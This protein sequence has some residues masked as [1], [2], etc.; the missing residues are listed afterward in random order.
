MISSRLFFFTLAGVILAV[1]PVLGGE[2]VPAAADTSVFPLADLVV[3]GGI[4]TSPEPGET[5][6]L[7]DGIALRDPG[8]LADLG[9][10][11]PSVSVAV[12]SRGD[13]HLMIRGAPE[14]HVQ[15]FLDGIPLN[16]PWDERVDLETIPITGTGRLAERRGLPTLLDG[17]GALAGS[18]RIL[19][20]DRLPGGNQRTDLNASAGTQ[21]LGRVNLT[22][23]RHGGTWNL[24]TAG[25]WQGRD[26]FPLP[27]S[28][29]P[30]FNSDL[31]QYSLLVRASRPVAGTGKFSFLATG[32][33]VE[34][35]VPPELHL[36]DEARFWRYPVRER[37]LAGA[38]LSLPLASDAWD[39]TA[40]LAADFFHQEIDPR[41]PDGWGL[42]TSDGQD[43]EKDF[44]R[45]AHLTAGLTRWLGSSGQ[46]TLQTNLRYTNHRESIVTGGGVQGFGQT[47]GGMVLEGEFPPARDW[48]LRL[49]AGMDFAMTPEA[50][51]KPKTDG[52]TAEAWNLRLTR[53]LGSRTEVYAST[54][55]RSRFPSLRELYSGALGKF[56]PNPD[57]QPERQDLLEIGFSAGKGRWKLA[58]AAFLQYLRQGIEK[59][60]L[61]GPGHRFMRVNRTEIRV[62]GL[63]IEGGWQTGPDLR[64]FAQHTVLA[65]RVETPTGF[66]QPAE[67]RP[68]YLSRLGLDWRRNTGPGLLVE[69][70]I[71]GARWSADATDLVNGLTRLPAAVSWNLRL[72]WRWAAGND[73]AG[74]HRTL[75]AHLRVDNLFDQTSCYQAG[76]PG[77]GRIVSAGLGLGF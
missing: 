13:S 8:S 71:T 31:S 51:D 14:R 57:L 3:S 26:S 43:Y 27:G 33:T 6:I 15:I 19:P 74:P 24:L 39:L 41:G 42:P 50:G 76:L 25:S 65:A 69:A 16:L 35:G 58:G 32:W 18:V 63:E 1:Q 48:T 2:Q 49:G 12:N 9:G 11:L 64:L 55:R 34:K 47:L 52:F 40:M 17:P 45:T 56:V 67:D 61:P 66:D 7:P 44:D 73:T 21:G 29:D 62:P 28:G 75:E 23:S 59:E 46:L 36:G 5:N 60:K 22:H 77:P 4:G 70:A 20:P 54:G 53:R 38:S 68:D 37:I 10:L 72:G 30:R